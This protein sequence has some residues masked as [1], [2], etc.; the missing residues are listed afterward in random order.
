MSVLPDRKPWEIQDA[1]S[2]LCRK[3]KKR[4]EKKR[5][6]KKRKEKKRKEKREEKRKALRKSMQRNVVLERREDRHHL[7]RGQ[8]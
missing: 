2:P 6:E 1:S 7:N 3:E 8:A 5:K 4:K